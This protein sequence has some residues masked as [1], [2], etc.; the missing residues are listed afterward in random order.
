MIENLMF[1]RARF[2]LMFFF[3]IIA[4]YTSLGKVT[5]PEK[6]YS[7]GAMTRW[8]SGK[9]AFNLPTPNLSSANRS[10]F[11]VGD[12]FFKQNWIAAPAS[13]NARD[14]V[15][16]F[17][18]ARSCSACHQRDGRGRVPDENEEPVGLLFR[19]SRIASSERGAPA[20]H[21]IYG[22][23]LQNFALNDLKPEVSIRVKWEKQKG[24]F[25]DGERFELRKPTYT[26]TNWREG[27]PKK[28]FRLSS[29]LA[30]QVFGVGLLQAIP[31]DIIKQWSD[32]NDSDGDGISGRLQRIE[33]SFGETKIGRFGWKAEQP[34]LRA[35]T[36]KALH[37]DMGLSS[38]VHPQDLDH[39]E[40]PRQNYPKG[41]EPEVEDHIL[42]HLSKYP[43]LLGVPGRRD[44]EDPK[45]KTGEELFNKLQCSQCHKAEVKTGK[46]KGVPE[47]S[48]QRI[49]PFTD[50][51][52]HDMGPD[53]ADQR[54]VFEA[55][56]REW[57]TPPLW[58]LG[59]FRKVNGY[60]FLLHD[61]RARSIEE[62]I[63]WHG[64]E[65]ENSKKTFLQLDRKERDRLKNF[66]LSL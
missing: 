43:M 19:I 32:P 59:L 60:L 27:P 61:G 35:Q 36:A 33:T 53:L 66:L 48:S 62:A 51:L 46:I 24:A 4:F 17:F 65:A 44:T 31:E 22:E 21:P 5:H 37:T 6:A 2:F 28:P 1:V 47:V 18:N 38:S 20:P 15:G 52:L 45:V 11:F 9:N 13:A 50:L 41:G 14:G 3:A 64:G 63:L 30:P 40:I 29:R 23:Q 16:P 49:Q 34:N 8:D 7:G 54:P 10:S 55:S 25:Q 12:S 58:G 26:M 56:G 39:Q 42:D 57:R